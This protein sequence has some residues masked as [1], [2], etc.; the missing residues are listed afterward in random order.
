MQI[1]LKERRETLAATKIIQSNVAEWVHVMNW[2]WLILF[3]DT[4]PIVRATKMEEIVQQL[5]TDINEFEGKLSG[6]HKQRQ[7]LEEELKKTLAEKEAL[8]EEIKNSRSEN[9]ELEDQID[10]LTQQKAVFEKEMDNI[11]EK[12]K[13]EEKRTAE[14]EEAVKKMEQTMEAIR[15]NVQDVELGKRKLAAEKAAKENRIRSLMEEVSQQEETIAKL[16]KE[17]RAQDENTKKLLDDIKAREERNEEMDAV[18]MRLNQSMSEM[19][20][21]LDQAKHARAESE[22]ERRKAEGDLRVTQETLEEADKE[23]KD[24]EALMKKKEIEIRSMNVK[25]EQQQA[26]VSRLTKQVKD[27][28]AKIRVFE[29]DFEA[30]NEA[31]VKSER[32]RGEIHR[33]LIEMS[34]RLDEQ[35]NATEAQIELGK[36]HEVEIARLRRDL[37]EIQL[38]HQSTVAVM[39]KKNVDG[40][41]EL[42][43]QI[44]EVARQK[45]KSE[46]ERINLQN[47]IEMTNAQVDCAKKARVE[48]ERRKKDLEVTL[49]DLQ[50]K[51]DEHMRQLQDSTSLK[52][53]TLSNNSELASRIDQL[54][55]EVGIITLAKSQI[56]QQLD[57]TK[58]LLVEESTEKNNLNTTVKEL[59]LEVEQLR[60]MLEEEVA[61]KNEMDRQLNKASAEVQQWKARFED[62]GFVDG[63]ML[64]EE[65]KKYA[66]TISEL[67]EVLDAANSKLSALERAKERLSIEADDAHTEAER[68]IAIIAQLEKKEKN[69]QRVVDEWKKKVDDASNE[70]DSA[71]REC[72]TNAADI[73]KQRSLNDILTVQ[74]EGLRYENTNLCQAIKELQSQLGEGGKN[75]HE[76]RMT[77]Q[78]VEVEKEELQ[79]ALD[80]AEAALEIEES[81]VARFHTEVNQI[82]TAIEKRLEEKEEEFENIRKNHQ[83]SLDSIQVIHSPSFSFLTIHFPYIILIFFS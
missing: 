53:R 5:R 37:E 32:A 16:N 18:K 9:T 70:L 57:E 76:M 7:N 68:Y 31:R 55:Q 15:R 52:N 27:D 82:R 69:F 14:E 1:D 28:E 21:E 73:F 25:L 71:Q 62:A 47:Q 51:S 20:R 83:H 61:A 66:S 74:F 30:E 60:T 80:E 36:R 48:I 38:K 44:I 72:R 50:Q 33:E 6:K 77:M 4:M 75:I 23:K 12:L 17:R 65:K 54:D 42:N 39:R 3:V 29:E 49:N 43:D 19:E 2:P 56:A 8:I 59:Q 13:A 26:V 41:A 81:K 67:E 58:N 22:K 24:L 45:A 79:R 64:D 35:R 78:R 10:Q 40:T 11:L 34:D 63:N 46:K